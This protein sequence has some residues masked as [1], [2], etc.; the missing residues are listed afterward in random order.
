VPEVCSDSG[1]W[2]AGP[3][4]TWL[5][6]DGACTG[7]CEPGTSGCLGAT[8]VTCDESGTPVTGE[9]CADNCV[10]GACVGA[11]AAGDRT[12]E[13]VDQLRHCVDGHFQDLETCPNV[14]LDDAC[15]GDCK[16]GDTRCEEG[17]PATCDASGTWLPGDACTFACAAEP[18][19][20]GCVSASHD[21]TCADRCGAVRD[22]CDRDVTCADTCADDTA[23]FVCGGAVDGVCGCV[24]E[25]LLCHG[26]TPATCDA[27]GVWVDAPAPC[28]GTCRDGACAPACTG[29]ERDCNDQVPRRCGDDGLW[30]DET[31]CAL[32][33]TSCVAGACVGECT[34][35][36]R[37]CAADAADTPEICDA[38]GAW[39]RA[40]ACVDQAC[41]DGAC[42][43]ECS[44]GS[45]RC[46]P[47][48]AA[49][50]TVL[51]RCDDTGTWVTDT[52]CDY[53]C[54]D[55][56]SAACT[57][58]CLPTAE[59]RC[60]EATVERCVD[61]TWTD[62]ETCTNGCAQGL[63]CQADASVCSGDL[64][65]PCLTTIIKDCGLPVTCD[66]SC[67]E[68]LSCGATEVN[69]CG[70]LPGQRRC[71]GDV[72]ELCVAGQWQAEPAC[73]GEL[74]CIT[75]LGACGVCEPGTGRCV[76]NTAELCGANGRWPPDGG[77]QTSCDTSDQWCVA[78]QCQGV[79]K[80]GDITCISFS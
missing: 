32:S 12:C 43:G 41:V 69:R 25:T 47:T 45:T 38:L 76:G 73:S 67:D 78:G 34:T 68:G 4:C 40:P 26:A 79:C 61:F 30:I 36:A 59:A 3:P 20:P 13:G 17:V 51:E 75:S 71:V 46:R 44:P 10:D 24:P 21:L 8:V 2:Q 57:G 7:T 33:D 28:P 15:G 62:T 31:S 29:D 50:A 53:V 64:G 23:G 1:V 19:C 27:A 72:P 18:G 22:N 11:C 49:F 42:V 77:F 9:T 63:C 39:E 6:L 14:C 35:S 16:P 60:D 37:R 55:A 54:R 66:A 80:P 48:E 56:P 58:E 52:T 5:C 74:T 70:C 65:A